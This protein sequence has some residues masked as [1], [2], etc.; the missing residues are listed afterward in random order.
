M[1]SPRKTIEAHEGW[2]FHISGACSPALR[3]TEPMVLRTI[4]NESVCTSAGFALPRNTLF[5]EIHISG[6]TT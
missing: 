5:R 1:L 3:K 4:A 6:V 2:V